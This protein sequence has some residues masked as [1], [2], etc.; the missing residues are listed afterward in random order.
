[1][2]DRR[3]INTD[4]GD[5]EEV[6]NHGQYAKGDIHNNYQQ[7]PAKL[8]DSSEAK[9]LAAVKNEVAGRLAQ[10]L[11]NR[12]YIELNKEED[13][14]QVIQPWAVDV[15]LGNQ[16]SQR[17]PEG[18]NIVDIFDRPGI[19]GRLLI[20]GAP[21]SGKTMMLLQL[22]EELVQRADKN[23]S[24]PVPVLLNLSAWKP[25]FK[26]I[27]SWMVADLKLKYGVR[28]D[29]AKKWIEEGRI[30]PLLDG[31]DE[32]MSERQE[33]C[34]GALNEFL[35]AWSGVPLV[36]CSRREEYQNYEAN[37]GLNGA[38]ILQPLTDGQIEKFLRGAGCE[39]LWE[40]VQQDI[41]VMGWKGRYLFPQLL[42]EKLREAG[43]ELLSELWLKYIDAEEKEKSAEFYESICSHLNL[44]EKVEQESYHLVLNRFM[45]SME[46]LARS[47]LLLTIL[48][49][50]SGGLPGEM[51]QKEESA[52]E[53]RRVLFEAYI[54]ERLKRR[55]VGGK[56]LPATKHG[57]KPYKD[58][59]KTKAWLG[60]LAW[61]L[62]E[63]NQT[64]FFIEK[65]QP[66]FLAKR[67]QKFVY[68]LVVGL[69][70]GL[71]F[72]LVGGLVSGLVGGLVGGLVVG[73]VSGLVGGTGSIATVETIK[74]SWREAPRNFYN[75]LV[76]GL[77]GGLV[78]GLVVGLVSGL[79]FGLVFGLVG[80]LVKSF[81]GVEI[82]TKTKDNQGIHQSIFNSVIFGL[83]FIP[84]GMT[85][86]I[87]LHYFDKPL[88]LNVILSQGAAFGFLLGAINGGLTSAIAHYSLRLTLWLFGYS[89][90]NYSKF[91]RY[92]T[93]RGF[94]QRVGGG[95]RF[96]HAFLRD[97]CIAQY[98]PHQLNRAIVEKRNYWQ[99]KKTQTNRNYW[100][101]DKT[102]TNQ[103]YWQRK[104]KTI[105]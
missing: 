5:Y 105:K 58:D 81:T 52:E 12:V 77:V 74:I 16:P 14:S 3:D 6:N 60:W 34:V 59:E 75:D 65:L 79:V 21:G 40:A 24:R 68:G 84:F 71:V 46:G 78:G 64:E 2:I 67:W 23:A 29:I 63:E 20:L 99:R 55:Y 56:N 44:M 10:S 90:L 35:P 43:F 51:W 30:L 103:N 48:V 104:K 13:P 31:L 70:V 102:P 66:R 27:P 42:R 61:R 91:L 73:L 18:T 19:G 47:P 62:I 25:E 85:I 15:K 57:Q 101:R 50:A 9:L 32:L 95:Y 53:W 93:E 100:Q 92:C 1:M 96:V 87:A 17:C 83:M 11:H 54:A 49:L 69:V 76:S 86:P 80:G 89:P 88:T 37:L 39:W 8:R 41:D 36:V 22:A 33:T 38:V 7:T 72:G 4:G 94:L 82:D 98:T 28:Q 97:H 26:D 45:D